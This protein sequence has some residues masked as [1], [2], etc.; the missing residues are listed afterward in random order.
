MTNSIFGPSLSQNTA[1]KVPHTQHPPL[2]IHAAPPLHPHPLT[3]S[4]LPPLAPSFIHFFALYCDMWRGGGV[5]E[6][7]GGVLLLTFRWFHMKSQST[8]LGCR[9]WRPMAS[10]LLPLSIPELAFNC[11]C[12]AW[13]CKHSH[14]HTLSLSLSPVD[15][16]EC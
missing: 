9:H 12:A 11:L 7:I 3:S 14:M 15:T 1:E 13:A 6:G 2:S 5:G 4:P 16:S 8:H 10:R